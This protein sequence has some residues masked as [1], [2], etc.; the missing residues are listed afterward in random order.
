MRY[1]LVLVSLL[2]G[3]CSEHSAVPQPDFT[4]LDSDSVHMAERVFS[5][6]LADA[7]DAGSPTSV[8]AI[9][10]D[11]NDD[12]TAEVLGY[13]DSAYICGGMGSCFFVLDSDRSNRAVLLNVPGVDRVEILGSNRD[14]WHDIE[15]N[16]E[17]NWR[18]NGEQYELN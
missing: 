18:W 9:S 10:F 4:Q 8:R 1:A 3:S 2:V 13:I 17:T 12:G 14:G 16:R 6:M 7:R 15:F 5:A 11:L